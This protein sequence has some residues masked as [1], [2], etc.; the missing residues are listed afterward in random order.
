M[1]SIYVTTISELAKKNGIPISEYVT[2]LRD[3][4]FDLPEK[5]A[6]LKRLKQEDLD[7]IAK[8][9]NPGNEKVEAK[10]LPGENF[11]VPECASTVITKVNEREFIVSAVITTMINGNIVMK[12]VERF[13]TCRSKAEAL[14]ETDRCSYK[15]K[16]DQT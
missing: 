5:A 3:L 13:A 8:L 7:Q 2:T 9:L 6:H 1:T 16:T 15:Y 14:L 11:V 12:E 10:P 4:G